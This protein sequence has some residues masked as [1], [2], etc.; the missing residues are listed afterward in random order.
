[1]VSRAQVM[2]WCVFP[3][4]ILL[5]RHVERFLPGYALASIP[6]AQSTSIY[7]RSVLRIHCFASIK[8]VSFVSTTLYPRLRIHEA[9]SQRILLVC[10]WSSSNRSVCESFVSI[11]AWTDTNCIVTPRLPSG[12]NYIDT[13]PVAWIHL[14]RY[15][16]YRF[17]QTSAC[18]P[19]NLGV[20]PSSRNP[21]SFPTWSIRTCRHPSP[22][23][24][25]EVPS[26][27]TNIYRY[28]VPSI[29]TNKPIFT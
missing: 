19:T 12:T 20:S 7:S 23:Y 14:Y 28:E 13:K 11:L 10:L 25:Y 21:P 4:S 8:S 24:R 15:E 2:T 1:M 5:P 29:R 17:E 22:S 18:F 16:T 6:R 3:G 26:I 9:V 27:R